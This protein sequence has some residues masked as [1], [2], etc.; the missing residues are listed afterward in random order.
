MVRS[1][2]RPYELGSRGADESW[3]EAAAERRKLHTL[4]NLAA[5]RDD[6][7]DDGDD[8]DCADC[9]GGEARD[10]PTA[11][12][13]E[14]HEEPAAEDATD[15]AENNVGD[16]AVAGA[17]REFSGEPAGNETDQNPTD[18]AALVLHDDDTILKKR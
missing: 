6:E 9:C 14:L 13:A 10:E 3:Q 4:Q 16:A 7:V 11:E 17:T 18:Q 12:D 1:V 2:L 5:A 8:D 15:Q